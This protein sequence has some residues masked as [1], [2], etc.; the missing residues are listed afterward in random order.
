MHFQT[1][2]VFPLFMTFFSHAFSEKPYLSVSKHFH[3]AGFDFYGINVRSMTMDLIS[4]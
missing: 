3:G 2:T 1:M 4:N